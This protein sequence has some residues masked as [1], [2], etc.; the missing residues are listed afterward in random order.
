MEAKNPIVLGVDTRES[1][2][3]KTAFQKLSDARKN[4]Y[5]I[6]KAFK[7]GDFVTKDMIVESKEIN[8]FISSFTERRKRKDG[9]VYRRLESQVERLLDAPQPVKII[10]LH[11]GWETVYSNIKQNSVLG[12][13][14]SI[15]AQGIQVIWLPQNTD[16]VYFTYR[17]AVKAEKYNNIK[18]F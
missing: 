5:I 4:V 18:E 11:G 14:A 7:V 12:Q 17:L 6:Y 3:T 10:L 15:T 1:M 9:T 2:E 13:I 16:W 8:D